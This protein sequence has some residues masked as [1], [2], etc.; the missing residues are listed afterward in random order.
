MEI[1]INTFNSH[2]PSCS[3]GF[4]VSALGFPCPL[5]PTEALHTLP[6]GLCL[7]AE[8][9]S[10][11]VTFYFSY[12]G[13]LRLYIAWRQKDV[14]QN[15]KAYWDFRTRRPLVVPS[16]PFSVEGLCCF[17]SIFRSH[18]QVAQ[19]LSPFAISFVVFCRGLECEPGWMLG[20]ISSLNRIVMH[21]H[22][23][24]GVVVITAKRECVLPWSG[25]TVHSIFLILHANR[26]HT[27][28]GPHT[29]TP[30]GNQLFVCLETF[31]LLTV[32]N[33]RKK[34]NKNQT[35]AVTFELLA[36]FTPRRAADSWLS[37]LQKI[38]W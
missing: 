33:W 7:S 28:S 13:L 18:F 26:P 19:L 21:W 35:T 8:L 37:F 24:P 22:R 23:L 4:Q 1:G 34:K 20:K 3:S 12:Y 27:P 2:C 25:V 5:L 9:F 11:A 38:T 30:S 15:S 36:V 29:K 31:K 17:P 10:G 14:F 32:P 6:Q 16:P